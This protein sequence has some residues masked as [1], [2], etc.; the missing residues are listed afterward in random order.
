MSSA[1]TV[2]PG[3]NAKPQS[4]KPTQPGEKKGGAKRVNH[5]LVNSKD[6]ASYPFETMPADFDPKKHFPLKKK[7]FK[8]EHQFCQMR[9]D[10]ARKNVVKWENALAEA[11]V[12]GG[13]KDKAGAKRLAKMASRMSELQQNLGAKGVN[14]G[15]VLAAAGVDLD[16]LQR[17]IDEAKAANAAKGQA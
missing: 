13:S 7:D 8:E 3:S 5:P 11:K 14:S 4:A 15:Q 1:T 6:P 9:L 17:M 2:K 16:A 10:I 12:T